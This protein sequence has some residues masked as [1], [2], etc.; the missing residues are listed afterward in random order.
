[1]AAE[2]AGIVTVAASA[3]LPAFAVVLAGRPTL[4]AP[5]GLGC[6]PSSRRAVLRRCRSAR[7][8]P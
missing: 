3:A 5:L 6:Q 8:C 7:S 2:S 1:M 4:V